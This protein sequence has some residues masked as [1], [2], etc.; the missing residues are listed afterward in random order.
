MKI[1]QLADLFGTLPGIVS[2]TKKEKR[3]LF[4]KRK[5]NAGKGVVQKTGGENIIP[6]QLISFRF[7]IRRK[8]GGNSQKNVFAF[9]AVS[10]VDGIIHLT[11]VDDKVQSAGEEAF[12]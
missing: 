8:A 10:L 2:G 4:K 7:C 11:V 6:G 3:I 12:F 9:E 5:R 1:P